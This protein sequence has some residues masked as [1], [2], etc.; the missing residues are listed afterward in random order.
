MIEGGYRLGDVIFTQEQIETRAAEI[1]RQISEDFAGEQVLLVGILRGAVLWMS[2]VLK[3]VSLETEIDF[4]AVS[5]YGDATKSTGVVR[6]VKDLEGSIEGKNVI[7]V[8]DIV[9][10]GVTLSYLVQQFRAKNP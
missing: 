2:Q 9:D 5:S 8:E 7:I 3:S 4:M 1:G 10:T 6:I